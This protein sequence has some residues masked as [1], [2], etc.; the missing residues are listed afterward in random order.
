MRVAGDSVSDVGLS[1]IKLKEHRRLRAY[2]NRTYSL[3]AG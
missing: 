1:K 3:P 2:G